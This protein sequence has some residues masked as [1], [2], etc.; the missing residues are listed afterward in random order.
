ML[1]F[2][3]GINIGLMSTIVAIKREVDNL[4]A[5]LKQA[6]NLVQD[7]HEELKINDL[8]TVKE[9]SNEDFESC[10][11]NGFSFL[12]H[13]P[14][15]SL[16]E[17]ELDKSKKYDEREP[18]YQEA[19]DSEAISKI[20]AELE[21][22][23]ERLELNMKTYS[24]DRISNYVEVILP[25]NLIKFECILFVLTKTGYCHLVVMWFCYRHRNADL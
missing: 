14:N 7:L 15:A 6:K 22:E 25:L 21:A 24:Q 17:Q 10:G 11:A 2:F 19:D 23:L 16:T 4:N 5:V 13:T 1:L 9:L 12:N 3:L 8:F 20:E 18:D